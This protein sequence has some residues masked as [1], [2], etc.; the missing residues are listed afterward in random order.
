MSFRQ[1]VV[2]TSG[3]KD[4]RTELSVLGGDY[5]GAFVRQLEAALLQGEIDIAV[6]SLKDLPTQQPDGLALE[7][8]ARS[9]PIRATRCVVRASTSCRLAPASGL[10]RREG[11]LSCRLRPDLEIIP[12]R[13]N[14]PPR[15][16]KMRSARLDSVV[17]AMAG[18]ER[19]G[20][21]DEV[22]E[23][24]GVE[25]SAIARTRGSRHSDQRR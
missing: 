22:A 19:L 23:V 11:E 10:A 18:L 8:C 13:G 15:L 25:E 9:A 2:V 20:L 24:L 17:L 3:D 12:I 21:L 5:G 4:R 1:R 16:A 14:V 7:G 6:H